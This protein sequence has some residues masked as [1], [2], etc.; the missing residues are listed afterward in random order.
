M[1]D[2]NLNVLKKYVQLANFKI[3]LM[4]TVRYFFKCNYTR[5]RY[6]KIIN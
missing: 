3:I 5:A 4:N 6:K 2:N 1:T